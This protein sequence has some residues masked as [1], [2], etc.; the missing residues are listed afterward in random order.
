MSESPPSHPLFDKAPGRGKGVH[1]EPDDWYGLPVDDDERQRLKALE[2]KL[3]RALEGNKV[4]FQPFLL[5]RTFVGDRGVRP[6]AGRGWESPDISVMQGDPSATPAVPPHTGGT[7]VAGQPNTLY[8][9]VWN[10]GLAPLIGVTVEFL[11]FNPSIA[12]TNQQPLFRGLARVN[13]GGRT[14][15]QECHKLV[16]CQAAWVPVV[17]NEGHECVIVRASGLGDACEPI[18]QFQPNLDHHVG[19]RNM[20]LASFGSSQKGLLA[21]LKE[22]L[23]KGTEL[24]LSTAGPDAQF[25]VDLL[26]PGFRISSKSK[27]ERIPDLEAAPKPQEGEVTVVRIEGV[28]KQQIVGGFTLVMAPS[29]KSALR[30]S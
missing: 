24:R 13:L 25:V 17:V 19:Q 22:T 16:K 15:P 23:P 3:P 5:I 18:H 1:R 12:F 11:V 4:V 30:Q 20:N 21:H 9:H 6:Y 26:A 10:L 29:D 28:K 14:A 7:P 8:A 27:E 2:E